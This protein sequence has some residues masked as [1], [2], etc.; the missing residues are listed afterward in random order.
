LGRVQGKVRR[1]G[2]LN[3]VKLKRNLIILL[4]IVFFEFEL[5]FYI[6]KVLECLKRVGGVACDAAGQA[7]AIE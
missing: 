2:H 7:R 4:I 6:A 5:E 3:K 1:I